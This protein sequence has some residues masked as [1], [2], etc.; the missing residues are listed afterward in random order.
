MSEIKNTL[1]EA[2]KDA[3]RS[4]DKDR[5]GTLRMALSELKKVEVDERIELDD[6]RVLT[7]IDKMIKQR[8]DSEKQYL[9]AGREDLAATEA[10]EIKTLQEFMPEA[11]SAGE[12]E[13]YVE[14]AI[15]QSGASS[16]KDMK[17]VM[18]ILKPQV[19]GRADMG[20]IS[21]QI[22]NKLS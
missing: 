9:E 16:M 11:L 18:E 4:K 3:M 7:I 15:S 1:N 19:Q 2:K 13:Q 8:K 12:I 14:N 5:L 10:Q 21:K 17:A 20:Q 6:S 22:K